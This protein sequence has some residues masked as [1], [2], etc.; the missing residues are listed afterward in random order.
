MLSRAVRSPTCSSRKALIVE[1]QVSRSCASRTPGL[2]LEVI[3]REAQLTEQLNFLTSTS[4]DFE[5]AQ[6]AAAS[7]SFSRSTISSELANRAMSSFAAH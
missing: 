3:G 6:A 4:L 1:R 7:A 5:Q 2:Q